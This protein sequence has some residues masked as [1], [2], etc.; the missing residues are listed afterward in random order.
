VDACTGVVWVDVVGG[1]AGGK[2]LDKRQADGQPRGSS[3]AHQRW[4]KET[5]LWLVSAVGV[6]AV[7]LVRLA[8]VLYGRGVPGVV[9]GVCGWL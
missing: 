3:S 4:G 1:H 8:A 2:Q 7:A 6:A 5:C 9:G